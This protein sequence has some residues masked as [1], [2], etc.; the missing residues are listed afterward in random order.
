MPS[1]G[2]WS[3]ERRAVGWTYRVRQALARIAT[4]WC[5]PD[6]GPAREILSTEAFALFGSMSAADQG[7]SLEVLRHL[8]QEGSVSPDLAFSALLH[9]VGKAGGG[10]TL[11]YRT[12]IVLLEALWPRALERLCRGARGTW[13]APFA[14]DAEHASTGAERCR[15]AGCSTQT[16][17]LVQYHDTSLDAVPDELRSDLERLQRADDAS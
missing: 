8:E 4:L 14:A 3:A 9:D 15:D 13:R 16:V 17:A 12:A 5:S 10:L 2:C 7:H 1:T 11:P 6:V